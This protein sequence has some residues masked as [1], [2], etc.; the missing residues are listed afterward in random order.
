MPVCNSRSTKT[1]SDSQL[2]PSVV[3]WNGHHNITL[4]MRWRLPMRT[5]HSQCFASGHT[6]S[7][8]ACFYCVCLEPVV[9]IV[10]LDAIDSLLVVAGSFLSSFPFQPGP[11]PAIGS[12]LPP[13]HPRPEKEKIRCPPSL[14]SPK[15]LAMHTIV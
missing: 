11:Q 7:T 15:H 14:V 8:R 2:L 12:F 13:F 4:A 3:F 5:M 1:L 6:M 9:Y 10:Y